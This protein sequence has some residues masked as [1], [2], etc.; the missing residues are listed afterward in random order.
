MS[1]D[2]LPPGASAV[3]ARIG[4]KAKLPRA[5]APATRTGRRRSAQVL[6]RSLKQREQILDAAARVIGRTK[7]DDIELDDDVT[8][9]HLDV[10]R[11][12]RGSPRDDDGTVEFTAHFVSSAARGRLH[13]VSRFVRE[14]GRWF[15]VDGVT[16]D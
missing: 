5:L 13:E 7:L 9:R 8:W 10:V 2:S 14:D 11:T 3:L 1:S 15:Y 4:K 6:E 12:D 16:S